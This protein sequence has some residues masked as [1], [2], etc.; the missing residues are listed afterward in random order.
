MRETLLLAEVTE[1]ELYI[2]RVCARDIVFWAL[3]RFWA[4]VYGRLANCTMTVVD[5]S[6]HVSW[7]KGQRYFPKQH[8]LWNN[9]AFSHSC[10]GWWELYVGS[11]TLTKQRL[12]L[13]NVCS[14]TITS[15]LTWFVSCWFWTFSSRLPFLIFASTWGAYDQGYETWN[16]VARVVVLEWE[17]VQW[18]QCILNMLWHNVKFVTP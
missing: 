10:H 7:M 3:F 6:L 11:E 8:K 14:Q 17:S 2:V 4:F 9:N 15:V 18:S 16:S 13:I 12:A 1:E 5:P